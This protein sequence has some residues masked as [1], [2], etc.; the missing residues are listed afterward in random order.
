MPTQQIGQ[1]QNVLQQRQLLGVQPNHSG[2]PHPRLERN[3][4]LLTGRGLQQLP[5][6]LIEWRLNSTDQP[7]PYVHHT[8]ART[9]AILQQRQ[10]F[11]QP[12]IAI[13]QQHGACTGLQGM[14]QCLNFATMIEVL[15]TAPIC[16]L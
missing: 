3:T 9:Y 2:I 16:P 1:L 11:S 14:L 15:R 6:L 5:Q 8:A 10:W 12:C 13:Q 7:F 4:G